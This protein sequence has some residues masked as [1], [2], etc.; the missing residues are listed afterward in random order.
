MCW[1][2]SFS[3]SAASVLISGVAMGSVDLQLDGVVLDSDREGVDRDV[4]GQGLRL[5]GP[6]VE[7]RSVA[8][9]LDGAGLG[10]QLPLGERPIVVRAAGLGREQLAVAVEDA[11]LEV[12]PLDDARGT[13]RELRELADVDGLRHGGKRPRSG[14]EK[15]DADG[16]NCIGRSGPAR[17]RVRSRRT[18]HST[19]GIRSIPPRAN[20]GNTGARGLAERL[21]GPTRNRQVNAT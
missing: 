21:D 5:A 12:L 7:Q 8:R 3:E 2:D 4:G 11:D 14:S 15:S 16:L 18:G 1:S 10:I 9:A 17:R 6:Q 20:R 13:G 19:P